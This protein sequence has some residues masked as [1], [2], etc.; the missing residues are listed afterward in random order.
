MAIEIRVKACWGGGGW[1]AYIAKLPGGR[2]WSRKHNV[3]L[4]EGGVR[5]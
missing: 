2:R 5:R 4:E 1:L 3:K